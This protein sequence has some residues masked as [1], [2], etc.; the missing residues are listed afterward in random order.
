MKTYI[1]SMKNKYL[2]H[3]LFDFD[4]Q[5]VRRDIPKVCTTQG[6][7]IAPESALRHKEYLEPGVHDL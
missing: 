3:S 1:V 6:A 2:T 5:G 4:K 7:I